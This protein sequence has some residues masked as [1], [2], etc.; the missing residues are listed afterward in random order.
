MKNFIAIS[1]CV[2]AL[3]VFAKDDIYYRLSDKMAKGNKEAYTRLKE[4]S[5][6]TLSKGWSKAAIARAYRLQNDKKKA[7]FTVKEY[8]VFE[9]KMINSVRYAAF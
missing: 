4:L 3:P 2:L 1:I 7:F 6:K 9:A 8:G 5:K